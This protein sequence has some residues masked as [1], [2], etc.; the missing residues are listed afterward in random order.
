MMYRYADYLK[1]D[2][3]AKASTLSFTDSA[4]ISDYAADA[5]AWAYEKGIMTGKT[6]NRL[7]PKGYATR[8]EVAKVISSFAKVASEK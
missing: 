7:D 6:G 3:S 5:L 2:T 1:L 4:D 8:A